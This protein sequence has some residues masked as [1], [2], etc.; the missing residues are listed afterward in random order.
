MTILLF[1]LLGGKIFLQKC[2][3]MANPEAVFKR[4]FSFEKSQ[5]GG[6]DKR[7][8]IVSASE[9]LVPN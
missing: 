7:T 4:D 8:P 1:L 2:F 9:F 5:H 6:L 3:E